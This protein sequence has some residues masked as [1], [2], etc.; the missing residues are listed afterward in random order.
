M[1]R[2][3]EVIK[4]IIHRP[5]LVNDFNY[6]KYWQDKRGASMGEITP[7]QQR[8]ADTVLKLISGYGNALDI[9]SGDGGLISYLK[10][11]SNLAITA[12]D[13]SELALK[14]L[15]SQG[16]D[17]LAINIED[18][19]KN[20]IKNLKF[21]YIFA[22]EVLEHVKDSEGLLA[23][24]YNLSE[25]VIFSIPNTGYFAHR[26]RLLF[27]KFPLQWRLS[28]S[29]HL[30]FWTVSDLNWWMKS[31]GYK[32]FEV[33]TYEGIPILNRILPSIFAMGIVVRVSK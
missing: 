2:L 32:N 5:K 20:D 25:T 6:E 8:R 24:L 3:K 33:K 27:G 22:F 16:F 12:S 10:E 29:E 11:Q 1:R 4:L 26:F 28:P 18:L 15:R 17:V 7:F 23:E 13:I 19:P 30:R 31:L 9:G 21:K 14:E